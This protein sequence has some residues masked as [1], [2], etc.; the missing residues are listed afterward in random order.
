MVTVGDRLLVLKKK[1]SLLESTQSCEYM[2]TFDV[3]R[4]LFAKLNEQGLI[5]GAFDVFR[6]R[7]LLDIDGVD[8]DTVGEDMELVLRLQDVGS[9]SA[10]NKI[11]HVLIADCYT[12][13]LHSFKRL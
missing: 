13:V 4:R 10:T 2:I 11:V 12:N 1:G 9:C 3:A 6:K 8:T 7:V 5:S